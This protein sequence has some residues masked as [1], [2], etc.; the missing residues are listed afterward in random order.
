MQSEIKSNFASRIDAFANIE[1]SIKN[2]L[3]EQFGAIDQF[4]KSRKDVGSE[5][6]EFLAAQEKKYSDIVKAQK[7]SV[8]N[9]EIGRLDPVL[10]NISKALKHQI[11]E[12]EL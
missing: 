11:E 10:L 8:E 4:V 12:L 9:F 2:L 5:E 7:T 3:Q 6:I 1:D